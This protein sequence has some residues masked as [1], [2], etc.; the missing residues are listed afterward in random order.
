MSVIG[1]LSELKSYVTELAVG[2][3]TYA[4]G[5]WWEGRRGEW[6][7]VVQML[8]LALAALGPQRLP[9]WP[10]WSQP[11]TLVGR[12]AGG[13]LMTAGTLLLLAGLLALGKSLT[14][15]PYPKDDATLVESGP[16]RLVRHPIYSG[17]IFIVYGWG[18]F[19]GGWLTVGYATVILTFFDIKARREEVWLAERYPAY[20]A[21]RRRVHKL[22]P[23]IY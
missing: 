11:W 20:G 15:V 14:A 17:L 16:Y 7:V 23:F 2:T 22:I 5:R 3:R 6:Y 9:A 19:I 12:I 13:G 10:A 8:L 18:L 21:Y 1:L 4:L